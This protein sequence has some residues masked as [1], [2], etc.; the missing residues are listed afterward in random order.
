MVLFD[1]VEFEVDVEF[2]EVGTVED[3]FPLTIP[4]RQLF[5]AESVEH[6]AAR[7]GAKTYRVS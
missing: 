2:K 6:T 3:T 4:N 5:P 1:D 7:K